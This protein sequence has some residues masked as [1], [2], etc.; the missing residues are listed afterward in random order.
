LIG[1]KVES[2]EYSGLELNVFGSEVVDVFV[3]DWDELEWLVVLGLL[4]FLIPD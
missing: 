2:A 1:L 3:G 4:D